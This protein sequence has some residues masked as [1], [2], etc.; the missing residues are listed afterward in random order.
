MFKVFWNFGSSHT[1]DLVRRLTKSVLYAPDFPRRK[2]L[3]HAEWAALNEDQRNEHQSAGLTAFRLATNHSELADVVDKL[4]DSKHESA[5]TVLG[6]LWSNCAVEPIR[7]AA[8]HTLRKI[9]TP[10]ARKALVDLIEDADHMSVFMAVQ[11]IFDE[12]P[13]TS[14]DRCAKYFAPD[15]VARPGG[16]VIP[17]EILKTFAPSSFLGGKTP[18]WTESRAPIWFQQ[19][20]RWLELCVNLRRDKL[21]GSTARQVLRYANAQSVKQSLQEAKTRESP[22]VIHATTKGSGDLLTRY[23]QG[24]CEGVWRELRAH[25]CIGGDL[26]KEAEEVATETMKRVAFNADLVAKRLA[27]HGWKPLYGSLRTTPRDEDSNV[28]KQIEEITGAPL[29]ISFRAFWKIVGGINFVWNYDSDEKLPSL[30]VDLPMDGLDPICINCAEDVTWLF[31]EWEYQRS[32]IDPELWD[33]VSLDLAPDYLHKANISGG[34]AYAIELPF[35]GADPIFENEEH[36]LPFVDYLRLCFRWGGFPRLE[37][38]AERSDVQHF[39]DKM[40]R[41]FEAF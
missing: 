5:V 26:L 3:T 31:E 36:N 18:Q 35:Y 37:R 41:D 7:I 4:G 40:T 20:K 34:A 17:N 28:I 27:D 14:F 24:Q 13:D 16:A 6:E 38:H 22:F 32:N 15:S 11:A 29:P 10:A 30:G 19:D 25:E 8:G 12:N 1:D 9:G 23:R 2:R 21:L 39:L 33:P